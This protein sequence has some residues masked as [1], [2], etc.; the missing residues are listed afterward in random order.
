MLPGPVA[1]ASLLLFPPK[2]GYYLDSNLSHALDLR[3]YL[4]QVTFPLWASIV[5]SIKGGSCTR[6]RVAV[7]LSPCKFMLPFTA[8]LSTSPRAP[9]LGGPCPG[10]RR[11]VVPAPVPCLSDQPWASSPALA[12]ALLHVACLR[13]W[14]QARRQLHISLF[15]LFFFLS[16]SRS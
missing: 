9:L 7:L 8:L 15:F 12:P 16:L 11:A 14:P 4:G 1:F 6:W 3:C 10:P 13:G 2:P 5:T